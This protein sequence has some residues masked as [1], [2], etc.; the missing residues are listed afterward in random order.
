[1]KIVVAIIGLFAVIN[2]ATCYLSPSYRTSDTSMS[3]SKYMQYLRERS[4][5]E[6]L[7][8]QMES[9]CPGKDDEL[10]E[11]LTKLKQC[12]NEVDENAE[13]ACS[14]IKNH[15]L[16]C[17]KPFIEL[18]ES[19]LPEES[20]EIPRLVF[21]A[22]NSGVA[23][24]CKV[25]G[26]HIFEF[27]NTCIF[28][29]NYRSMRC[30]RRVRTKLQQFKNKPPTKTEICELAQSM[31][32]CLHNHLQESCGN[33]ITRE[34][35]MGMFDAVTAPCNNRGSNQIEYNTVNEVVEAF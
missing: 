31:K 13:T 8:T 35:F 1:M 6:R 28:K 2:V 7:R 15:F 24:V 26:E 27:A 21:E 34:S 17:S 22:I 16:R 4:Q 5:I 23:Y 9:I 11:A 30:E 33:G 25:D 20:R 14:A 18:F 32:P 19:C 3:T 29:N 10:D 12:S